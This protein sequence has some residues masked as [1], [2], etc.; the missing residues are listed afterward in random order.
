MKKNILRYGPVIL[1]M[2]FMFFLS[3]RSDLPA[4]KVHAFDFVTKKIAHILEYIILNLLW[5]RAIAKKQP[6]TA[7]LYSLIFAFTDET[8]QIFIPYRSGV[9]RDVGIDFIGILISSL[10]IIKLKLW[11]SFLLLAPEKKLRP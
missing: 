10:L 9:L 4:T 3:S 11:N 5:Y 1:W 8:H 6:T 7:M 2:A